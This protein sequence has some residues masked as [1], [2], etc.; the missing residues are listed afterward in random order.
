MDRIGAAR[1]L[2]WKQILEDHVESIVSQEIGG[3]REAQLFVNKVAECAS[4]LAN[5][6]SPEPLV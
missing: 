3:L 1:L 5:T 2:E 4:R 6:E